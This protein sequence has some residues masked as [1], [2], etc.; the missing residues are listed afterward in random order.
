MTQIS[1]NNVSPGEEFSFAGRWY[2]RALEAELLHHPAANKLS[3]IPAYS[4]G[5]NKNRVPVS[6]VMGLPVFVA[7]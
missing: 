3:T 6:F 5:D 2:V 4:L 7:S 1:V